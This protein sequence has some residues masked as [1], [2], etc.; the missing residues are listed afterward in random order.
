MDRATYAVLYG[1]TT[2]DRVRLADTGLVVEV[3]HDDTEPGDEL[4]GGC[5]KTVREG[6]LATSRPGDSQLDLLV[7]NVLLLDPLLGVRKTNIGVK[8]GRVV[9]VGRAGSPDAVSDLDL[10]VGPHTTI[11]PAEGLIA[12]PGAVDSH[13]HLSSPALLDGALSAGVTTIVGMGVGGAWDVGVNPGRHLRLMVEAWRDV[14]LNVAFLSRGSATEPAL[15]EQA[16]LAGAGGFKVHED[17]GA[18][19]TVVDT[20]LSV[21][22]QLDVPVALHTDSL[23][24]S[25][26]LS[27]TLSATR[28][29][30]V[31]AYHVEGGGGHPDLLEILAHAHVL[32]SSTTPTIPYT[33]NTVDELF[34]MTM[35]VHRQQSLS[36]GDVETTRS[37]IR[38][39]AIAAENALHD[40]GA[41]S[42]IN[43]DAMGM[44]RVGE[45]LRR[46]WQLAAQAKAQLG[47]TAGADNE[48]VLRFLA[49]VTVNP[50]I[51]HG[52]AHDVGSIAPGKLADL[53]LWH[54]AWFGAKPEL[55]LKSGFVAWGVSGAGTG[56]TR[57]AQPRRY[58]P[59]FGGT[60]GAPRSLA[61][62]FVAAEALNDTRARQSLV[63]GVGYAAVSGAR[64]LTRAH[65]VRNSAVPHV[66]VP[67]DGSAVLVD[68][69][70]VGLA[71]AQSLPL[72]R[73][74][75]LA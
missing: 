49:K 48:R 12:T 29:R 61:T 36:P 56:S 7:S 72:T 70:P 51:A 54:P 11:I 68:G 21:A 27:D 2:G 22:D 43:S 8:D 39:H 59:F 58:R 46:T 67:R 55:V 24:E 31:H 66:H 37:R 5:G 73:L 15:L 50:A 4:L 34:P 28:G 18:Q 1:P 38:A 32:P 35:T 63:S 25:G 42:I 45:T 3:E 57:L 33:V 60:G 41:V 14:P 30:T 16:L 47:G 74:H 9:A 69:H 20:C 10:I 75:H 6:L 71:P 26:L 23:N 17:F 65:M 19:P 52:L 13:V 62:V 53:V 40:M 44:G 64:G